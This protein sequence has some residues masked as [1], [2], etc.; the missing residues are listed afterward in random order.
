M[1][2]DLSVGLMKS[3]TSLFIPNS[4]LT[5][6]PSAYQN[7]PS[8]CWTHKLQ[9]NLH[10]LSQVPH[11]F[12][13]TKP[14]H[15]FLYYFSQTPIF[16]FISVKFCPNHRYLLLTEWTPTILFSFH[17]PHTVNTTAQAIAPAGR[18]HQTNPVEQIIQHFQPPIQTI[19]FSFI[20]IQLLLS[21]RNGFLKNRT[22]I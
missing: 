4:R 18:I 16:L 20:K 14:S 1:R 6:C 8:W 12:R 19:G 22:T 7:Y 17:E 15:C 11:P 13:D 21:L 9:D 5:I 3:R 10:L 2:V